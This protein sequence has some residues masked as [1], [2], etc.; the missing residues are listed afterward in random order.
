MARPMPSVSSFA[1]WPTIL[2]TSTP[3]TTPE[4]IK[5]WSPTSLKERLIK[6]GAIL[7]ATVDVSV[8]RRP[9]SLAETCSP[10][11]ATHRRAAAPQSALT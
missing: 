8:S 10:I 11:P 5:D 4:P 2:A 6:L 1:R 3:Q 9:R 7:V